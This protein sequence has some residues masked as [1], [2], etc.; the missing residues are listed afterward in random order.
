MDRKSFTETPENSN[1]SCTLA[2]AAEDD[3]V[4]NEILEEMKSNVQCE[5]S[6]QKNSKRLCHVTPIRIRNCVARLRSF[7]N[8]DSHLSTDNV[9]RVVILDYR[10]GGKFALCC[11]AKTT[12]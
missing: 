3:G 12:L 4:L 10:I 2:S 7:F 6:P 11:F 1:S 5:P 9:V 8:A